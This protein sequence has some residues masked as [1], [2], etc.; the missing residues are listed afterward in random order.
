M[1]I[2]E[3]EQLQEKVSKLIDEDKY[4]NKDHAL[5]YNALVGTPSSCSDAPVIQGQFTN[6]HPN[7]MIP[8]EEYCDAIDQHQPNF[9]TQLKKENKCRLDIFNVDDLNPQETEDYEVL[10]QEYKNTYYIKNFHTVIERNLAVKQPN[11]VH[12]EHIQQYNK[13]LVPTPPAYL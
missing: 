4:P 10:R 3:L 11:L 12:K 9:V 1:M 7:K 5:A 8:I 13:D 2:S 6:W